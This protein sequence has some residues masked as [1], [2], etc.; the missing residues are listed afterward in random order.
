MTLQRAEAEQ[1]RP[2]GHWSHAL[3]RFTLRRGDFVR[4][5]EA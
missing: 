5:D 1:C 2:P 4:H 3:P